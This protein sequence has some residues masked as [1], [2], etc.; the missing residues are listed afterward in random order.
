MGEWG[1]GG[2]WGGGGEQPLWQKDYYMHKCIYSITVPTDYYGVGRVPAKCF[3][4]NR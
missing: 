2:V 1:N 3:Y 4:M